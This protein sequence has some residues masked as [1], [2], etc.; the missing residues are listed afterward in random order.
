MPQPSHQ[1]IYQNV[2]TQR[3]KDWF[4][5]VL[6]AY[7]ELTDRRIY[8]RRLDMRRSTMR[9]HPVRNWRCCSAL[10]HQIVQRSE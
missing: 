5:E 10:N 7:P 4:C 3:I 2:Q 9:A 6:Q 8:L 1:C